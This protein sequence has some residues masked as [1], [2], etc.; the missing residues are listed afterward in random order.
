[1]SPAAANILVPS[2]DEATLDQEFD[3]PLEGNHEF[4]ESAEV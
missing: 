4:P 2:A 1:M 3:V